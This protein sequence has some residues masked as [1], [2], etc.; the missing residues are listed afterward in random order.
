MALVVLCFNCGLRLIWPKGEMLGHDRH[1]AQG[2]KNK[3]KQTCWCA[4]PH[5]CHTPVEEATFIYK[6]VMADPKSFVICTFAK[7]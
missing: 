6:W 4:H 2:T 7:K 3:G 5:T 1:K